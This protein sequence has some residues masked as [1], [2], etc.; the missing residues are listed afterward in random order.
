ME[1]MEQRKQMMTMWTGAIENLRQRD[2]DIRH[3][4]EVC[5]KI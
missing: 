5:Y 4:R 1:G 2:V 3:M